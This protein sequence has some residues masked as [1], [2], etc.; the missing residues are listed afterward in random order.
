MTFSKPKHGWGSWLSLLRWGTVFFYPQKTPGLNRRQPQ[1]PSPGF[2]RSRLCPGG[3]KF[4]QRKPKTIC[5]TGSLSELPETVRGDYSAWRGKRK[6]KGTVTLLNYEVWMS[7]QYIFSGEAY[8]W[9][10]SIKQI[11]KRLPLWAAFNYWPTGSASALW[12]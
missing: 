8:R 11:L 6:K 4:E 7:S 1:C 3:K 12:S 5:G 9:I 2:G 10:K